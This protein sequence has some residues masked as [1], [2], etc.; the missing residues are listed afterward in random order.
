MTPM[1]GDTRSSDG[2][3]IT[4]A[5]L[6]KRFGRKWALQDCSLSVPEGCV[7]ALIGP[8]GAGKTTLLRM[9]AGL[10][11]PSAGAARVLGRRPQQTPEF[12]ESVGYLAQEA[13]LY[14]RLSAEDHVALGQHVNRRW[15]G[16]LVRRRLA[17]LHI[18]CQQ[19]V[20]TLSGGQRAQVALAMALAKRPRV[21]LLDE[22]MAALDPLARREF[23][24]SL[25]EAVAEGDLTVMVSSHLVHDLERICDH[26]ILLSA[27]RTQVCEDIDEL[28]RS[29]KLLTGARCGPDSLE[30]GVAVLRAVQTERQSQL[31]VRL[32]G[33][34][35]NPAWEV[36]DLGLEDIVLAYMGENRPG[37]GA[38]LSVVGGGS[39]GEE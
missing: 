21:L 25:T 13:P 27:S 16:A 36:S 34:L 30:P 24:A 5:G 2:D 32:D 14:E 3:A 12:L 35:L 28:L 9:L 29:H 18:P 38:A 8:N 33:S 7:C 11:S 17:A 1:P 31:L 15:D 26:L 37:N 10:S 23:L 19:P 4:T 20:R 22:P 6:G 39:G